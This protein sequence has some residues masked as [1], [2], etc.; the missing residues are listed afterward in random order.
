MLNL[1]NYHQFFLPLITR[2]FNDGIFK[3]ENLASQKIVILTIDDGLSYRSLEMLNLLEKYNAKATFFIH[4]NDTIKLDNYLKIISMMLAQGHEIGNHTTHDI[5]SRS[6][7]ATKFEQSFREADLFLKDLGIKPCFFRSSG[8]LYDT[9][10]MMPLLQELNY[11]PKFIMAS[12]LPWDTHFSF[13]EI[14]ANQLIKNIFS[15]AIVVFHD[16]QQKGEGR[17]ARTFI[18]LTKFLQGMQEKN[19]QVVNLSQALELV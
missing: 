10:I 5:P 8:G 18:S 19:Y 11:F 3:I 7:C 2:K 6:L 16:G 15:G 9:K 17:L 12:F 1:V 13:P 4:K 14:Y